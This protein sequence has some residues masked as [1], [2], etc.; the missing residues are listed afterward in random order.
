M[1]MIDGVE[2]ISVQDAARLAGRSPETI[3]RW[4]WSGRVHAIKQGNKLLLRRSDL[5]VA[6]ADSPESPAVDLRSWA[7]MV[8]AR[9]SGAP[10]S[11]AGDLILD[12]RAERAGR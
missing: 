5:P 4:V 12:D 2:M 10:G 8:L 6:D 1:I 11:T 7:E 9:S 3:R